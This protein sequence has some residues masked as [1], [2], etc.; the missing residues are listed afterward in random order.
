MKITLKTLC[1]ILGAGAC[2]LPF[3]RAADEP[4]GPPPAPNA[5]HAPGDGPGGKWGER[6]QKH[7][8]HLIKALGLTADQQSKWTAFNQQQAAD[9][10]A[11]WADTSLDKDQKR[12]KL[13]A[14]RKSYEDQRKAVLT[15]EQL[16]KMAELRERHE[17]HGENAPPPPPAS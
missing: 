12:E 6:A 2:A 14:I 9:A 17:H 8:Q 16:K 7:Q 4:A 15:P 10:K 5:E 3:V 11:V 13:Q 1:L